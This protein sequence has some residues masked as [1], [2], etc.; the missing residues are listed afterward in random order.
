MPRYHARQLA[1]VLLAVLGIWL[2]VRRMPDYAVSLYVMWLNSALGQAADGPN[3]LVLHS[4]HVLVS[5]LLGLALILARKPLA[6][7]LSPAST[8][9]SASTET[10]VAAGVAV[11]GI[12]Y[13]A[14]GA[15][16]LG[17]QMAS[18]NHAILWQGGVSVVIGIALFAFS[19]GL[20]RLWGLL[21]GRIEL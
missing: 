21:R 1:E 17:T 10:L 8:D 5:V 14:D 11:V 20:G 6:A 9:V 16:T 3:I 7:W 2:V 13:L 12:H 19:V 4:V 15:I 18:A